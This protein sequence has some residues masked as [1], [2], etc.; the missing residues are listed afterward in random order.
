ML[1]TRVPPGPTG[2]GRHGNRR[3]FERDHLGFLL[4]Q[5]Q[6]G[7][8]VRLDDD[9][10]LVNSPVLAEEVLKH[11]NTTYTISR[12]LL[13]EPADGSRASE[14]LA[15]WMR[16]RALTG[17]GLNR[18]SM[19]AVEDRLAATVARHAESWH[20]RGSI[21]AIPALEDLTAHLIAEFCLGPDT[22]T[23]P[24]LLAR[25]QDT[26][27]PPPCPCPSAGRRCAGSACAGPAATSPTRSP[28]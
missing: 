12:D 25:L 20:T 18:P 8:L 10:Y 21:E 9:L 11:T 5:Q 4:E 15:L 3:A 23:V 28:P 22:G 6:Y 19:R 26:L 16:A 14:D 24:D 27:L 1:S 17:R 7:D 2:A 13:G